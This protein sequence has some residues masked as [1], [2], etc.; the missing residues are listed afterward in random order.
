VT[1]RQKRQQIDFFYS[2][3]KKTIYFRGGIC[4]D[5]SDDINRYR[6]PQL[7]DYCHAKNLKNESYKLTE[8]YD[9]CEGDYLTYFLH[10]KASFR[11]FSP[12]MLAIYTNGTGIFT[13]EGKLKSNTPEVIGEF[14]CLLSVDQNRFKADRDF[15]NAM[16]TWKCN[17]NEIRSEL[18]KLHGYDTKNVSSLVR[19]MEQA[20]DILTIGNYN[21]SLKGER[22]QLIKDVRAGKFTY[23]EVLEYAERKDKELDELYK[24]CTLQKKPNIK[25]INELVLK[26]QNYLI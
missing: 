23:E 14:V 8:R 4:H 22:L 6:I 15:N 24:V 2:S 26:L 16:W 21:P 10:N 11:E 1:T 13:A 5:C 7:I 19:L 3:T 20:T 12:S 25:V 18:E 17:R 9:F